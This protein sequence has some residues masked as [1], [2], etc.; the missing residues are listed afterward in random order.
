MRSAVKRAATGAL[1]VLAGTLTAVVVAA[2]PADARCLGQGNGNTMQ[3]RYNGIT[4]AQERQASGT[5]DGDGIYN[6]Q[7]RDLREDGYAAQVVYV[8]GSYQGLVATATTSTW[9]NYRFYDQTG[10]NS[11]GIIFWSRP[12]T[13]PEIP[14]STY[15]Y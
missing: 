7:V 4:I 12:E 15:G 10:N 3:V 9:K 11:A 14:A 8:D 5:C 2:A 13:R 1:A 6:G